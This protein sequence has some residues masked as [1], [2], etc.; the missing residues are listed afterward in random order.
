MMYYED[1]V[2]SNEL[3][4]IIKRPD[5]FGLVNRVDREVTYEAPGEGR[6]ASW[7]DSSWVEYVGPANRFLLWC[8][9]IIFG[10]VYVD[11]HPVFRSS[12]P[13]F[14]FLLPHRWD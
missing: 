1:E 10:T 5:L 3:Y 6:K 7:I 9:A 4:E 14:S 2:P 13:V 12:Y 11:H 8:A